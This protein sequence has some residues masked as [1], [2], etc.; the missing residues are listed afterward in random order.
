MSTTDDAGVAAND[1]ATRARYIEERNKR[2]RAEGSAQYIKLSDSTF[3]NLA[4]DPWVDHEHLN[5]LPS[6]LPS[7]SAVKILILGAGYGGLL[8]AVRLIESGESA[9]AI[10][11]VDHAGGFG[12]TWYWNRYPGLMCDIESYVYMP[13]LEETGFM[14]KHKYSYGPELRGQAVRIAEKWHLQDKCLFRTKVQSARWNE[15]EKRWIVKMTEN[16][17]AAGKARDVEVKAQFIVS[18][19]GSLNEPHMPNLSGLD[20]FEGE[21]FHTARWDYSITGGTPEDWKLEKL[22]NKRVGIIGTGATAIQVVPQLAQWA[23]DLYV[24]QRTPS[25]VDVRG[26]KL[27]DPHEWKRITAKK[28]WQK[29]RSENLISYQMNTPDKVNMVDDAWTRM[30]G[31]AAAFGSPGIVSLDGMKEHVTRLHEW[32]AE[33]SQRVRARVDDIVKSKPT[34]EKLKAWYPVWCKTPTFHDDY[35]P[36]FNQPNVQLVDTDGKGIEKVTKNTVVTGGTEYPIDVLIMSTGFVSPFEGSAS[37]SGRAGI[38]IFGRGSLSM[39]DK[40][41]EQGA[42]TLHGIATHDFPNLFFLG[43]SQI[44]VTV[45]IRYV[46][47]T[48]ASHIA[49]ILSLSQKKIGNESPQDLIIEVTKDAEEAWSHEIL[50]RAPWFV[51]VVGCTPGFINNEGETDRPTELVEKIKSARGAPWGE[52]MLSYT[53][54]LREWLKEGNLKGLK[55]TAN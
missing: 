6:P 41:A 1:P 19:S 21:L 32:D 52:G 39:G 34:A 50:T 25:S 9:E 33:R 30:P 3:S 38:D 13:L 5:S 14:P 54:A 12:G 22:K 26:Q 44:G 24:F 55:I 27:T 29:E 2:L 51:G 45:N 17:G 28:G 37:P 8:S 7:G 18:A 35:L 11:L 20:C 4:N 49:N 42:T 36:A 40:W 10:R 46:L 48:L 43:P 15:D 23:K 31:Y 16:R 53:E 47:D